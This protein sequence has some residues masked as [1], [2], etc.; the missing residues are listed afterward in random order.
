MKKRT[1]GPIK[2]F[3]TL[4]AATVLAFATTNAS[5]LIHLIYISPPGTDWAIG[6]AEPN[7][8]TANGSLATGNE[9]GAGI[10]YD[11]ATKILSFDFGYGSDFGFVDLMG[12][13]STAHIHGPIA[14]SFPGPPPLNPGTGVLHPLGGFHTMGTTTLTGKFTGVLGPLTPGEEMELLMGVWYINSHTAHE[15]SG[16]IR[17]Q[18]FDV[19][20]IPLPA[21]FWLLLAPLAGMVGLR[22]TAD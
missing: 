8:S 15:A 10:L 5:A 11:D 21:A 4:T 1:F 3:V 14:V 22:R 18:L 6:L 2:A 12:A 16:E 9:I 17:G 13:Y 7:A 19:G 20:V